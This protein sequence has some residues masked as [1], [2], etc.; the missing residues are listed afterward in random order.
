MPVV[1]GRPSHGVRFILERQQGGAGGGGVVYEGQIVTPTGEFSVRLTADAS[2][3]VSVETA[4]DGTLAEKARLLVR[5][6]LR[7]A[8]AEGEAPPRV[9]Q[10]WRGDK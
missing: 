7:H 10:R 9:I 8:A 4:A 3:E 1:S 5:T 2:A 6:A